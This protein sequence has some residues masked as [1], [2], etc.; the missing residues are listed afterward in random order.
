MILLILTESPGWRR[1]A[2][3]TKAIHVPLDFPFNVNMLP[4][5]KP[6]SALE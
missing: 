4:F 5:E 2:H 3:P 1:L 6:P